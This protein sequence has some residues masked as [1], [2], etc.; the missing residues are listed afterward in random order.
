MSS[1]AEA[2]AGY[3]SVAV[4]GTSIS[5]VDALAIT[6]GKS[7]VFAFMDPDKA[8]AAGAVALRK[9]LALYPVVYQRVTANRDPKYLS[10]MEIREKIDEQ[11]RRIHA[12]PNPAQDT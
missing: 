9:K 5:D 4:L 7:T 3:D 12:G 8:G 11:V 1:I 6:R 10:R 2:K